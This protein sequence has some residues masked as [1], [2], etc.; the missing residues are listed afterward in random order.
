M[1]TLRPWYRMLSFQEIF[2][3]KFCSTLYTLLLTVLRGCIILW[4]PF[5]GV[6]WMPT[7]GNYFFL[8]LETLCKYIPFFSIKIYNLQKFCLLKSFSAFCHNFFLSHNQFLCSS[9]PS[10]GWMSLKVIVTKVMVLKKI[11][12]VITMTKLK[13]I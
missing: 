4:P 7:P 9:I 3:I 12:F 6:L 11:F 10:S 13:V 5:L 8:F 2:S 1:S